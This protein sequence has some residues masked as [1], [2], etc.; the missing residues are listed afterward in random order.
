M[1]KKFEQGKV[2]IYKYTRVVHVI[3]MYN[4]NKIPLNKTKQ[5]WTK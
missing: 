4:D 3:R 1:D 2:S 5:E